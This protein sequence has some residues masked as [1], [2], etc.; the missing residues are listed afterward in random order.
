MSFTV[1][2]HTIMP[3][4]FP[5]ALGLGLSGQALQKGTWTL[6]VHNIRDV[7]TDRHR[8]VDDTP[9]GGGA[10]MVFRPDV[11]DQS[12]A[13]STDA[14][15][16]LIHFSPRGEPFSQTLAKELAAGTG[17]RV[18]CGRYEGIDQRVLDK[19]QPREISLGDFV[20]SG[21]E[22]AAI[23]VI[24]AVVR[25]LPGVMGK[26]EGHRDESFETGLLE[27]AQYT[28]PRVWQGIEAPAVLASGHHQKIAEWQL[29]EAERETQERRPD[30][31]KQHLRSQ[32]EQKTKT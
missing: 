27:H 9:F 17:F 19:W 18:L 6:Q 7:T 8:T 31:W 26:Q 2:A 13:L 11:V 16:P 28:Q 22:I 5:G 14:P 3:D 30:L 32:Q 25:L 24:D 15:G 10:G 4:L 12:L 21:G 23:P 1:T 29:A 20:L